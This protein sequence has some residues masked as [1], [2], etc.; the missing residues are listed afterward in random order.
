[1][2][3]F[4]RSGNRPPSSRPRPAP[5]SSRRLRSSSERAD[6][7]ARGGR[8]GGEAGAEV[9]PAIDRFRERREPRLDDRASSLSYASRRRTEIA[10]ALAARPAIL[11]LDE[12]AAGMNP[13]ERIEM[14]GLIRAM[15]D[16]G[17]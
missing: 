17:L 14:A 16:R 6:A 3:R 4:Q 9:Q 13:Y 5:S 1:M 12:P 7:G 15:R 10:R 11:L 8:A 2:P